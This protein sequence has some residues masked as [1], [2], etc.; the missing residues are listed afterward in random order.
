MMTK[1]IYENLDGVRK[2]LPRQ[3]RLFGNCRWSRNIQSAAKKLTMQWLVDPRRAII[4]RSMEGM[5]KLLKQRK[6][7]NT[8]HIFVCR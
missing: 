1:I 8:V 5:V 3:K 4:E 6:I 7:S 2:R